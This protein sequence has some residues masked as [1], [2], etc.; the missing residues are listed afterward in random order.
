[1]RLRG[2][3]LIGQSLLS[4]ADLSQSGTIGGFGLVLMITNGYAFGMDIIAQAFQVV[5]NSI[6][7]VGVPPLTA[8][9][10]NPREVIINPNTTT[11]E[12]AVEWRQV[13]P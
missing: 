1:M 13:N 6:P 11:R 8:D 3:H 12:Y 9:R 5:V 4:T 7:M 2:P 10:D